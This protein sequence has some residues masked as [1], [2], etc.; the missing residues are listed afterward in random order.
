VNEK[1]HKLDR[2]K[3]SHPSLDSLFFPLLSDLS[4]RALRLSMHLVDVQ[5]GTHL[6]MSIIAACTAAVQLGMGAGS[7]A[8]DYAGMK[9]ADTSSS[10]NAALYNY[11]S[12]LDYFVVFGCMDKQRETYWTV[13][14]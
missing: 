5:V 12:G 7:A 3:L 1:F 10:L 13:S 6:I 9:V 14:I 11:H 8:A 4:N 2:L